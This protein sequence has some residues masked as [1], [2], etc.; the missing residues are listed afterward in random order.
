MTAIFTSWMGDLATGHLPYR[1]FGPLI[2]NPLAHESQSSLLTGEEAIHQNWP[3]KTTA[4]KL[5]VVILRKGLLQCR[6]VLNLLY[7]LGLLGIED[8]FAPTYR[9]GLQTCSTVHRKYG[10]RD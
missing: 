3:R 4:E 9:T 10:A 8:H 2:W 6:L 7:G 5:L 1:P